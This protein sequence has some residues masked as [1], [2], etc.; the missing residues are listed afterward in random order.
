MQALFKQPRIKIA[1]IVIA[2]ALVAYLAIGSWLSQIREAEK[3]IHQTWGILKYNCDLRLQLVSR[4]E[5]LINTYAPQAEQL[6]QQLSRAANEIQ[7]LQV[8]ESIL[9][10]QV[11]LEKFSQSQAHLAQALE[12]MDEQAKT[13]PMLGQNR[14]YLLLRM[15]L[16][17]I[18]RQIQY[19]V[20]M[21]NNNIHFY[22]QAISG[23]PNSWVNAIMLHDKPK[24][25][26]TIATLLKPDRK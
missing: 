11:A 6:Q 24:F 16:Q 23:I 10:D 2:G 19:A 12:K 13:N 17:N 25:P 18:E 8:Q 22:N 4:F 7:P 21:L 26:L 3:H 5:Q 20:G 9:G 14:Q 1:L 15:E